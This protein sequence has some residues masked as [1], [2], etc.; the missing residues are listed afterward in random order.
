M[1]SANNR[2]FGRNKRGGRADSQRRRS[3]AN[4]MRAVQKEADKGNLQ[5]GCPA[6]YP[7]RP[8]ERPRLY[9]V[10]VSGAKPDSARVGLRE[11]FGFLST[12]Q[13]PRGFFSI[14]ARARGI[15]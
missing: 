1:A 15:V 5:A 9:S 12:K 2:K 4:K 13:A 11:V 14:G 6:K 8:A 3:T 10:K 7:E